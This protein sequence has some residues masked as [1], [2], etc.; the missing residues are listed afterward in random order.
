MKPPS[1]T[2]AAIATAPGEGGIAIVRI[3]GP[4]S[5]QVADAVFR[6][7][8]PLPSQRAAFTCVPGQVVEADGRVL[9]EALLLIF[10][11]PRSFT[12]EDVVELQG[13]GGPAVTRQV[14]RR[15]LE[16]GAR[17]AEPGEFT[18][19]AFLH[20]RIDLVQAEAVLDLI[21][22]RT[23][24]AAAAAVDQLQGSLT[25]QVND[26]YDGCLLAAANLEA[27]LDF[28][29]QEL[30][31]NVLEGIEQRLESLETKIK[32][33]L[34]S[35][36]EGHLLRDGAT[37]VIAGRPNVGKSTLLNTLLGKDRAIVSEHPGTTRD[38]IEEDF[39]LQGIAMNLV[40]TAG[41]RST[42]CAIEREGIR[43]T[44]DRLTRADLFLYV[45]D[46]SQN[47]HEED[48][49][50]IK[51]LDSSRCI[52]VANKQ[53]LVIENNIYPF[54][55]YSIVQISLKKGTG[56]DKLKKTMVE[57][58]QSAPSSPTQ[59]AAISE[60]HRKLLDEALASVQEA[61]AQL[62]GRLE[63]DTALAA[64]ALRDAVADIGLIIGREYQ[65]DLLDS[66]FS[67]FCIG[68]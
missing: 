14:L 12:R 49:R 17:I 36:N 8:P 24:R 26:L 29:D 66:I 41:L 53:D 60:R 34:A 52:V 54:A 67:R 5:L 15:V 30:P 33:L 20:G 48:L 40:D 32:D 47:I 31:D 44:E 55:G 46:S 61:R 42:E 43:R 11:A 65:E 63:A 38:F 25:R 13:H 39:V 35:W 9:D 10:R 64:Q 27:T 51:S 62:A 18:R 16:A 22:A 57:K 2:I 1:D 6:C 19:R 50:R 21:R 28:S 37:V 7:R 68:K 58:L 56:L 3:S 23:D 45:V 4:A 59:H